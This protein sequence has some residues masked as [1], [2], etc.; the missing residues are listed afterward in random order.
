MK[1]KSRQISLVLFFLL[2]LLVGMFL[3]KGDYLSLDYIK[4]HRHGLFNFIQSHYLQAVIMFILL[5]LMTA[6]F[7]PGALALTIAGGMLFGT[8]PA[9]VYI[10]IG[11][12]AGAIL[13]FQAARFLLGGWV[14]EHF[15]NQL[16][17]FNRE[18][19]RHGS[20]YLLVL[21]VLPIIPFF[22]VNYCAGITKIPLTTFVWTTSLG[23]LPGSFVYAFVGQQLR[24][25]NQ[26][27]DL[28]S[29]KI[30]M[31]LSLLAVFAILPVLYY[32]LTAGRQGEKK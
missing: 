30:M 26:A 11:A 22:V 31:A 6:L 17:R 20:N 32:H 4:T 5:Y 23:M 13:A 1:K 3:V 10:N 29:W 24:H 14:Q 21:R 18:M 7:L 16:D 2:A 27:Q 25:V 15:K 19:E 28:F 12:T 8:V 9:L